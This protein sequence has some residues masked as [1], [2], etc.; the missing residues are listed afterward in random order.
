MVLIKRFMTNR[1]GEYMDTLYFECVGI[2]HETNALYTPQQTDISERKN[3]VLKEM[4]NSM[5]SYSGLSQVVV[6]GLSVEAWV[7]AEGWV[8]VVRPGVDEV[9][10]S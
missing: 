8:S 2:I 10:E 6:G 4:V 9:G 3:G 7:L 1:G 5:L